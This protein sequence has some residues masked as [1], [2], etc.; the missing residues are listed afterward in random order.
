M[1][2]RNITLTMVWSLETKSKRPWILDI[3]FLKKKIKGKLK[4]IMVDQPWQ[5]LKL[6]M[7]MLVLGKKYINYGIT[8]KMAQ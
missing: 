7:D 6:A 8:K 4:N 1:V 3:H 2:L 5:K